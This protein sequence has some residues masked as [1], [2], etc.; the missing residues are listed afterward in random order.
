MYW[1]IVHT[2]KIFGLMYRQDRVLRWRGSGMSHGM[3]RLWRW[4][5][6]LNGA[7][8]ACSYR[9]RCNGVVAP[10]PR[11]QSTSASLHVLLLTDTSGEALQLPLSHI[12]FT[13][14]LHYQVPVWVFWRE[15]CSCWSY[16]YDCVTNEHVVCPTEIPCFHV[17]EAYG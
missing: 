16:R 14:C 6:E 15:F 17:P 9:P 7:Q 2:S 4:W 12:C 11:T 1:F 3:K 8:R 10:W 13:H 5:S